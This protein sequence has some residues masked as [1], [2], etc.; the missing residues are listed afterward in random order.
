MA[1]SGLNLAAFPVE[2]FGCCAPWLV[3][4]ASIFLR[5]AVLTPDTFIVLLWGRKLARSR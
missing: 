4:L 5:A 3:R 1:N 2:M